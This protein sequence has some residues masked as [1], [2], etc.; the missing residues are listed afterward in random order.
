MRLQQWWLLQRERQGHVWTSYH[1]VPL[2]FL[3]LDCLHL[4]G[5]V[6][7]VSVLQEGVCHFA[8]VPLWHHSWDEPPGDGLV[9]SWTLWPLWTIVAGLTT[10]L[11]LGTRQIV[12]GCQ[13]LGFLSGELT[14]DELTY[15]AGWIIAII[16]VCTTGSVVAGLDF[17]IKSFSYA[18]FMLGNCLLLAVFF[19]DE[20]W[21][22]L[23]VLVGSLGFHFQHLMQTA[24][25]TD[26]FAQLG[27]GNGQ[28]NDGKGAHPSWMDWWTIFY[29]GWW[30]AWAPFVGTFMARISRGRTIRQV[31]WIEDL[32]TLKMFV[33][34]DVVRWKTLI[35]RE[36]GMI[37]C[38]LQMAGIDGERNV[39]GLFHDEQ[40]V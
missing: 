40:P 31:T 1:H 21:Y 13:R 35:S 33:L 24:F 14:D 11:G 29:W 6:Y 19:L 17:G 12:T 27:I 38:T 37:T 22:I 20:T 30:V 23:N 7:G 25:D 15:T 4:N 39:N 36:Y 9:M 34:F 3:G 10:S 32:K 28:P 18:A 16:T 8:S 26:A 2:G 5:L